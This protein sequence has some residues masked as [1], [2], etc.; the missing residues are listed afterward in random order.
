MKLT[1]NFG[2][3]ASLSALA[4]STTLAGEEVLQNPDANPV[5]NKW[6]YHLFN[7]TPKEL[8]RDM[9]TDRPDK[10]E[11]AYTVDAGH[12][13]V[14]MDFISYT[15]DKDDAGVRSK[16]WNI[17]PIN[18]KA[19]LLN[20]V[21]LQMV[22]DSYIHQSTDDPSAGQKDQ[23]AGIGDVTTRLKINLWG[24]DGGVTALAIMPFIKAPTNSA[25]LGNDS[26]EG[27]VIIPLAVELPW[28]WGMG[29]MTEVDALRSDSDA[30]YDAE[31]INSI[32]FSHDIV[33][34]LG[35]YVEFFSAVNTA[36]DSDWKGTVDIGLTFALTPDIQIDG[37]CNF[38]VTH[39]A[40]DLNPFFGIS[41]RF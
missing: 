3:I 37:G 39:A 2:L 36:Q 40:D 26:L 18:V 41:L 35:G 19:G 34:N 6:Q 7:P 4:L 16:T 25:Q 13:Q 33:G 9:S 38:G 27:G 12:Y 23:T 30:G 21:D 24:N 15:H 11:S 8:M 31:F 5:P 29:L 1:I 32:T 20:N 14:E 22:F 28:G 10:T 17:A